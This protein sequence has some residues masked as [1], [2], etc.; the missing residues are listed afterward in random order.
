[1]GT[2]PAAHGG[3]EAGERTG[4]S[5]QGEVRV[6]WSAARHRRFQFLCCF[7]E[8]LA[9]SVCS[10]PI[11]RV[12]GASPPDKSGHYKQI[13]HPFDGSFLCQKNESGDASPH[14]KLAFS[15]APAG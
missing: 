1:A 15:V 2:G 5:L 13:P 9:A 3:L 8:P 12:R 4:G 11:Y 6:I 14:S 7:V 10:D